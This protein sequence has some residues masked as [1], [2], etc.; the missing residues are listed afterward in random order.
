V[1]TSATVHSG[2]AQMI[3][4]ARHGAMLVA[5]PS[6]LERF[7]NGQPACKTPPSEVWINRPTADEATAQ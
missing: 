4:R 3:F 7:V 2:D 6:M 5:Y 1:L